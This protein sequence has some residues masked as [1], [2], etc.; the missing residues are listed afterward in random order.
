[1]SVLTGMCS[2]QAG[3]TTSGP[4]TSLYSKGFTGLSCRPA[5][6]ARVMPPGAGPESRPGR[7]AGHHLAVPA[8]VVAGRPRVR[9]APLTVADHLVCDTPAETRV[10]LGTARVRAAGGLGGPGGR[11]AAPCR[12]AAAGVGA[13]RHRA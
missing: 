2:E 8:Q 11:P 3:S 7:R 4:T 6:R 9:P 1:M 12:G 10:R 13:R 5:G